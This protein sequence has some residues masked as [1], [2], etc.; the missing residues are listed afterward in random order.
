MNRRT[1]PIPALGGRPM[2]AFGDKADTAI[3]TQNVR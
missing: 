3:A 2:T 1:A